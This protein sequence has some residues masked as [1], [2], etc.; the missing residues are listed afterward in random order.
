M[1][2]PSTDLKHSQMLIVGTRKGKVPHCTLSL[3]PVLATMSLIFSLITHR[4]SRRPE[5]KRSREKAAL[6]RVNWLLG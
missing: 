3:S 2:P 6:Y 1:L 4:V 5:N